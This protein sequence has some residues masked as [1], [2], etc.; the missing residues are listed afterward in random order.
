LSFLGAEAARAL[1]ESCEPRAKRTSKSRGKEE[2]RTEGRKRRRL[3][4]VTVF[5]LHFLFFFHVTF[6]DGLQLQGTGGDDFE[7]GATL[8]ARNDLA[9]IYL[10][11]FHIQI[12]FAFRTKN[13]D[14]FTPFR[15]HP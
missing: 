2:R 11:F 12:G 1:G 5:G 3:R 8:R 10:F 9:L 13:H 6:F 15:Y 7:I 14:S 4:V